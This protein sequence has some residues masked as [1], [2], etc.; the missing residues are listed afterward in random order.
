MCKY[1]V[2]VIFFLIVL[3]VVEVGV[4]VVRFIGGFVVMVVVW[5]V[6]CMLGYVFNID[7]SKD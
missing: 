6:K 3:F 5:L 2:F 4:V 7:V 1:F